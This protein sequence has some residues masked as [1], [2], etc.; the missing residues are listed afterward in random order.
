MAMVK[1][2]A[3]LVHTTAMLVYTMAIL[4]EPRVK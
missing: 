3:V 1:M 4:D 2:M